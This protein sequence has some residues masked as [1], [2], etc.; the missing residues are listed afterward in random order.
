VRGFSQIVN[1]RRMAFP[2]ATVF[3]EFLQSRTKHLRNEEDADAGLERERAGLRR[4]LPRLD[5]EFEDD[6]V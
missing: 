4:A 2:T 3:L 5:D 1:Q 6:L